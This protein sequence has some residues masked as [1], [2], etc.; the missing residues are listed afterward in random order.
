MLNNIGVE[1]GFQSSQ[2]PELWQSPG[3]WAGRES[4][5]LAPQKNQTYQN[6]EKIWFYCFE[7]QKS[8]PFIMFTSRR[9]ENI[10]E[11]C[12]Q[13]ISQCWNIGLEVMIKTILSCC[14]L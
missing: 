7:S 12:K 4:L 10:F 5:Y 13:N 9:L 14:C 6:D 8:W 1:M 3:I 2:A 11:N